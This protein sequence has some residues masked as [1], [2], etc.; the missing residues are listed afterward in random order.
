M[1]DEIDAEDMNSLKKMI[2]HNDAGSSKSGDIKNNTM[3]SCSED[4]EL[5]LHDFD[6]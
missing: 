6:E 2:S 4:D 3:S 1:K 5:N